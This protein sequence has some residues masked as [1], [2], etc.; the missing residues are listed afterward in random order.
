MAKKK[1][2]ELAAAVAAGKPAPKPAAR[3]ATAQEE[4]RVADALSRATGGK[5]RQMDAPPE[6]KERREA[7]G[8]TRGRK[9][10]KLPRVN[11]ALWTENHDYVETMSNMYGQSMTDFINGI[12]TEHRE[13]N[14][15][16]QKAKALRAEI[17]REMKGD[18]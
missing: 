1:L 16:Y 7:T 15:H 10:C 14:T 3:K 13:R 4:N 12:I 6:E 5:G 8:R 18:A 17:D 2:E 9:G 11:L